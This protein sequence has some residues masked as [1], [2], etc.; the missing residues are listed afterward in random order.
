MFPCD[1]TIWKTCQMQNSHL[2]CDAWP[3]L[4]CRSYEATCHEPWSNLP[5][6]C[7]RTINDRSYCLGMRLRKRD[8][9]QSATAM[10]PSYPHSNSWRQVDRVVAWQPNACPA[11]SGKVSTR[12][13]SSLPG[14]CGRSA[15]PASSS[16]RQKQF[17]P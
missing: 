10:Q 15:T 3:H 1:K 6:V 13:S 4:D 8:L 2:D 17:Q 16:D 5:A 7:T 14:C 12:L 11:N 9:A